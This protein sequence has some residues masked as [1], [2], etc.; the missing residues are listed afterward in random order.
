M[1]PYP[2]RNIF[3]STSSPD[4]VS[5]SGPEQRKKEQYIAF[6]QPSSHKDTILICAPPSDGCQSPELAYLEPRPFFLLREP[7]V[8]RLLSFLSAII[9]YTGPCL[10]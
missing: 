5:R 7:K 2:Q 6:S 9:I 3:L 10:G 8:K 4:A 1:I